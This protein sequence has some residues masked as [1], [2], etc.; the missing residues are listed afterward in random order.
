[1]ARQKQTKKSKTKTSSTNIK[2]TR[3]I[4]WSYVLITIALVSLVGGFMVFRSYAANA[5]RVRYVPGS[6]GIST[7]PANI[8]VIPKQNGAGKVW[9]APVKPSDGLSASGTD[10]ATFTLAKNAQNLHSFI[11]QTNTAPHVKHIQKY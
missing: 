7:S 1:M 6:G 5:N 10:I 2:T 11:S 4:R 3:P 8:K 9:A